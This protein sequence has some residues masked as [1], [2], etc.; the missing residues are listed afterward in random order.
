V[1]VGYLDI[2]HGKFGEFLDLGARDPG[3]FCGQETFESL[4]ELGKWSSHLRRRVIWTAAPFH[5]GIL[6]LF[7]RS[8][9]SL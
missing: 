2:L 4:I 1:G 6:R 8:D 9:Y 5:P 7:D 3:R